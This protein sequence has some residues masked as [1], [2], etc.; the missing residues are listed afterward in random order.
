MSLK[1]KCPQAKPSQILLTATD[2]STKAIDK[3]KSGVYSNLEAQ[4]GLPISL[5]MKYFDNQD[6]GS[7]KAKSELTSQ[8]NYGFFNLL[9]DNYPLNKYDVI[10]CRNVLIYQDKENKDA[11]MHNLYAALKPGGF[12]LMGA[13]ESMIGSTVE[14]NQKSYSNMMVFRKPEQF[15]KAA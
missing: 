3:C 1:E 6:D 10:F 4:R 12:L 15:K 8:V 9:T 7:W 2:I 5:L 13:G 11:I 14:F